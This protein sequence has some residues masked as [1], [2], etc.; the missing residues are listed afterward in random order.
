MSPSSLMSH[1]VFMEH[2][3]YVLRHLLCA[4]PT[5]D[6]SYTPT[7]RHIQYA[8]CMSYTVSASI[9]WEALGKCSREGNSGERW[10]W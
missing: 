3:L 1:W 10:S 5:L 6:Y 2:L 9:R 4:E 7:E 8:S